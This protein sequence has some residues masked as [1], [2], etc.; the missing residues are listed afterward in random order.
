MSGPDR[1]QI[2]TSSIMST[3]S[4]ASFPERYSNGSNLSESKMDVIRPVR[5]LLERVGLVNP[6]HVGG[7]LDVMSTAKLT[8]R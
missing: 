1:A 4:C 2:F 5:L 6:F 3:K 8:G 7:L